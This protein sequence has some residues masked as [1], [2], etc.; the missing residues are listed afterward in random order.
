MAQY[1]LVLDLSKFE[2][3]SFLSEKY[4][5]VIIKKTL[6]L[7]NTDTIQGIESRI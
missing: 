2:I 3:A 1:W 5:R 6:P 4:Y 7:I